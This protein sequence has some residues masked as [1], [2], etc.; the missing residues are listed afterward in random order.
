MELR[1]WVVWAVIERN[2][3]QDDRDATYFIFREDTVL[4]DLPRTSPSLT[5]L[6]LFSFL[7]SSFVQ[8]QSLAEST[9]DET[10]LEE[11]VVVGSRIPQEAEW[12]RD[13]IQTISR[14]DIDRSSLTSIGDLVRQLSVSGAPINTQFNLSGN[15]GFPPDGGGV[16]AGETHVDLR[17]LG[18]KRVL[19]LVDGIR[20][21]N[22]SSAGGVG[23]AVDLNTIPMQMVERIE[24]FKD[25]A[26]AIYGS[27]ALAGVVNVVTKSEQNELSAS[28]Y[29]GSYVDGGSTKSAS[30]AHGTSGQNWRIL[31]GLDYVDQGIIASSSREQSNYP[32]PGAGSIHGS[33]FTPQGRIVFPDPNTGVFI[34]C[35]LDLGAVQP[36][37]DPLDPCGSSDSYHPWSNADRFNYA[38][39]NLLRTP[40]ERTGLFVRLEVDTTTEVTSIV[41]VVINQRR[42]RNRAAPEPLWVGELIQSGSIMDTITIDATNPFN[43]FGFDIGPSNTL[44]TR[45][46]I[47]SGP[48][49]FDQTVTTMYISAQ[50][51]GATTAL[52]RLMS[53]DLAVVASRNDASQTKAG[54]HNARKL[55]QALG[56]LTACTLP[57]VPFNILGGEGSIT[58]EMLDWVGFTQRDSSEQSQFAISASVNTRLFELPHGQISIATGFEHRTLEGSFSPDPVVAAGDTAGLPAQPTSGDYR[59]SEVF[60][61]SE[62]PILDRLSG[63]AALRAFEYSTFNLDYVVQAALRWTPRDDLSMTT[64]LTNGFRAPSI[65]ELFGGH[66]RYDAVI[67]DPCADLASVTDAQVVANCIREGVPSDGSYSQLSSQIGLLTGGNSSLLPE[68][69]NGLTLAV[70]YNPTWA[71]KLFLRGSHYRYEVD[72]TITAHDA[73][74]VLDS[75]YIESIGA[76]CRFVER[77]DNGTIER[78]TNTLFNIGTIRT[79]GTDVGFSYSWSPH[80]IGQ[81][82]WSFDATHVQSFKEISRDAR[83]VEIRRRELV[84]RT[85]SDRGVPRLKYTSTIQW[86]RGNG[87][88]TWRSRFI[89]ELTE[90]CSNFLDGSSDSLTNLGLCS[91]PNTE[92]NRDS[93]NTLEATLYHSATYEYTLPYRS[94]SI[95]LL[96]G[97]DN[98]LDEETPQSYSSTLNGYDPSTHEIPESRYLYLKVR[99]SQDSNANN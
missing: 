35:A 40:S 82:T 23:S 68:I 85:E 1:C 15:T 70:S 11:V 29:A 74:T 39:F 57:C 64:A 54:A 28:V 4:N 26:S 86:T 24:V 84:G 14:S 60:V 7:L 50:L 56:P 66:T 22:G 20:W 27:D 37:Y 65:G 94:H 45:R 75:C 81:L 95:G 77:R 16:A 44:V 9:T 49:V 67:A 62:V 92:V 83:G 69:S 19:V 91:D 73:Q 30:L 48:R 46:P 88:L 25:G 53:W 59:V 3:R 99:V 47:E 89:D 71:S 79:S 58:Q 78:F 38:T 17:H 96:V 93:E 55:K 72:S 87:S 13:N 8:G 21:I 52:G 76:F 10:Q 61:E 18:S 51:V 41:K 36:N 5:L 31:G 33:T 34:N 6:Y 12:T 80:E 97:I 90:R 32:K 2:P 63:I 43:H 98:F 42:S